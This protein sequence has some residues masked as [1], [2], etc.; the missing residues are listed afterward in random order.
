M[1]KHYQ[2]RATGNVS[3]FIG[4]RYVPN[5]VTGEEDACETTIYARVPFS[6]SKVLE[7]V[8]HKRTFREEHEQKE[9]GRQ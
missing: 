4:N 6:P 2:D 9:P 5:P 3:A 1:E 7:K 8:E